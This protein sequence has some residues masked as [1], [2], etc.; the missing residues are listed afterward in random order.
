[1]RTH[2]AQEMTTFVPPDGFPDREI[3]RWHDE[4]VVELTSAT[5]YVLSV[6]EG[7][8]GV[9]GPSVVDGS[10]FRRLMTFRAVGTWVSMAVGNW[11]IMAADV[12]CS[13][14]VGWVNE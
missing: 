7:V 1:M 4:Q 9:E 13:E 14:D 3:A 6:R 12:G 10:S 11:S 5:V 8:S 2:R